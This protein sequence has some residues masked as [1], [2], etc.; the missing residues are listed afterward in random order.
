MEAITIRY[1]KPFDEEIDDAV[2]EV[3]AD[4]KSVSVDTKMD[5]YQEK[6]ASEEEIR[7]L[8]NTLGVFLA[9]LALLNFG[10]MM[11]VGISNRKREFAT[12]KS[13]GMTG[14]QI[15]ELLILEGAG[16]GTLAFAL[17]VVVGIP[18]SCFIFRGLSVWDHMPYQIPVLVNL[19]VLLLT[20]GFCILI[21]LALYGLGGKDSIVEELREE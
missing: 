2:R 7:L 6:K 20:Y 14:K 9:A 16:Y 13:I 17:T 10:N 5:S 15:R 12:L 4:K 18:I 21:P 11:A 1:E 8:G 19:A 3:F